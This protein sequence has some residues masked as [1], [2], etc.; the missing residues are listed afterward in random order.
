MP[1]DAPAGFRA[2]CPQATGVEKKKKKKKAKKEEMTEEQRKQQEEARESRARGCR[3]RVRAACMRGPLASG[4]GGNPNWSSSCAAPACRDS[5][6]AGALWERCH[7][8]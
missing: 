5:E 3:R 7:A 8:G 2:V 1:P 6:V 4:R